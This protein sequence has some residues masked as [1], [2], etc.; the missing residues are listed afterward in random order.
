MKTKLAASN[1]RK[2]SERQERTLKLNHRLTSY[3]LAAGALLA[4]GASAPAEVVYYDL[5]GSPLTAGPNSSVFFNLSGASTGDNGGIKLSQYASSTYFSA[6]GHYTGTSATSHFTTTRAPYTRINRKGRA[7]RGVA[8]S[9]SG[10]SKFYGSAIV[11]STPSAKANNFSSTGRIGRQYAGYSTNTTN[12]PW[13]P[14]DRAYLAVKLVDGT[15]TH[16]GWADILVNSDETI[17]LERFAFETVSGRSISTGQT[18]ETLILESAVSRKNH[19]GTN[20]D[21]NLP[22]TGEPA[23]ECRAPGNPSNPTIARRRARGAVLPSDTHTIVFTFSTNV[24]SGNVAVTSGN[25]NI[26]SVSTPGDNTMTVELSDVSNAQQITVTLEDVTDSVNGQ[27]LPDTEVSMNVLFGDTTGNKVVNSS[28]V[29]QT[30]SQSGITLSESNFREDVTV[31]GDIN[32]SDV[33]AVKS[34]S[35]SGVSAAPSTP[36]TSRDRSVRK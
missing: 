17:T 20:H 25:A 11:G 13:Y 4:S 5:T 23:V 15:G 7:F 19:G 33:S 34:Q 12:G 29:A 1:E 16:F 3:T 28:D 31:S 35:G 36:K 30:K 6:Q 27:F 9:Y 22:L 32:G 26:S 18:F 24:S 8:G 21:I 14:N 2:K 10:A